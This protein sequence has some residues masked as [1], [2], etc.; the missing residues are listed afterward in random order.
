M[1]ESAAQLRQEI[2]E[3]RQHMTMTV[4]A[5]EDRVT[6]GRIIERRRNRMRAGLE[7]ARDRLMGVPEHLR[8]RAAGTGAGVR[9]E[10]GAVAHGIEHQTENNPFAAGFLAF[11]V[12]MLAATLLPPT[13]VEREVGGK[14]REA[15]ES[16]KEPV[17]EAVHDLAESAKE[18]GSEAIGSI[19]EAG[20]AAAGS[21]RDTAREKA[22]D[23]REELRQQHG[24]TA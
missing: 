15:A 3:T 2:D 1:G 18:H 11:G 23:T 14:A 12:G 5:I 22:A 4:D 17:Q 24:G 10:A 6:P 20:G 21:V 16:L 9:D 13:P 7:S 19:Q 8:D